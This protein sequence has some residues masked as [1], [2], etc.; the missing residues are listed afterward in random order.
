MGTRGRLLPGSWMQP[1]PLKHLSDY[2]AG[3]V[4]GRLWLKVLIGM[5]LGIVVGIVLGPSVGLVK[6]KAAAVLANWM[7]F[8]GH[9]FLAVIQMI[10]IPLVVASV[11]RGLAAGGDLDRLKRMGTRV[12]L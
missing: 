10:V 6:P 5:F 4:A 3:L 9:L 8:P 7:A 11:I 12:I 1:R 2:L